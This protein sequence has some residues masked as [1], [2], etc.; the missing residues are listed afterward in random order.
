MNS[1]EICMYVVESLFEICVK[2]CFSKRYADFKGVRLKKVLRKN[3]PLKY[4]RKG[5][6]SLLSYHMALKGSAR[7]L[8]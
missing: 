6:Q 8:L 7:G 3:H 4:M 2:E 5:P 1:D